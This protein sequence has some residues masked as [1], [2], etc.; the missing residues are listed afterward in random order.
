MPVRL[1]V[2]FLAA[3]ALPAAP[4]PY[5]AAESFEGAIGVSA[6]LLRSRKVVGED[7]DLPPLARAARIHGTVVVAA[8]VNESGRVACLR[9]IQGHPLLLPAV[10]SALA[11]WVFRPTR[12]RSGPKRYYGELSFAFSS[13]GSARPHG[14]V[15]RVNLRRP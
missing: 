7:P 9:V 12:T 13:T 5:C 4:V 2:V 6:E 11:Q 8:L 10:S 14:R 1:Q 15:T 3:A